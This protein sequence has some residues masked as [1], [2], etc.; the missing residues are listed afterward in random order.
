M[1]LDVFFPMTSWRA[2]SAWDDARWKRHFAWDGDAWSSAWDSWSSWSAGYEAGYRAC[3]RRWAWET[4]GQAGAGGWHVRGGGDAPQSRRSMTDGS[5]SWSSV[6]EAAGPRVDQATRL[7]VREY[8]VRKKCSIREA[9]RV[10]LGL[11]RQAGGWR[12]R[13]VRE[14][15]TGVSDLAP[16]GGR[17][18]WQPMPVVVEAA[19]ADAAGPQETTSAAPPAPVATPSPPLAEGTQPEIERDAGENTKAA[20]VTVLRPNAP[21]LQAEDWMGSDG[22]C[23]ICPGRRVVSEQHL[24]CETHQ[25]RCLQLVRT[26]MAAAF[27]NYTESQRRLMS[28]QVLSSHTMTSIALLPSTSEDPSMAKAE[29]HSSGQKSGANKVAPGPLREDA[30]LASDSKEDHTEG[31]SKDSQTLASHTDADVGNGQPV[32]A[33]PLVA[34]ISVRWGL[35]G[36]EDP[37][38]TSAAGPPQ[39]LFF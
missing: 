37:S 21:L 35:E 2:D 30:V 36:T 18:R 16:H 4:T 5:S 27:P 29:G 14:H 6:P 38:A 23:K 28:H 11:H 31:A 33:N 8:S 12:A 22:R 19:E 17:G 13:E 9:E 10:L 26:R 39:E 32:D 20:G 7:R 15:E 1:Q 25:D 3:E 24:I 34:G